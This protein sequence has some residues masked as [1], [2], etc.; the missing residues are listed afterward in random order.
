MPLAI[1]AATLLALSAPLPGEAPPS[2]SEGSEEAIEVVFRPNLAYEFGARAENCRPSRD[3]AVERR[4]RLRASSRPIS[5]REFLGAPIHS[6]LVEYRDPRMSEAEAAAAVRSWLRSIVLDPEAECGEIPEL[7][8]LWAEETP[9][10]VRG[11][12]VYAPRDEVAPGVRVHRLPGGC[13]HFGHFDL[14]GPSHFVARDADGVFWWHRWPA[15]F[16]R[17]EAGS[18]AALDAVRSA[19]RETPRATDPR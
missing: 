12:I 1:L 16:P 2:P 3:A 10:T 18:A 5:V 15:C 11:R 9:L 8:R 17:R 4:D 7:Q 14:A 6:V 19:E 13:S